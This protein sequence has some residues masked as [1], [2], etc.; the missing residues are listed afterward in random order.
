[1]LEE[2][3]YAHNMLGEMAKHF[4]GSKGESRMRYRDIV[5]NEEHPM[6]LQFWVQ[7]ASS[8]TD[9]TWSWT[10]EYYVKTVETKEDLAKVRSRYNTFINAE[11]GF[12]NK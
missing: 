4:Q 5:R 10:K 2:R 3:D 6:R 12:I 7:F 1:M 8:C 11:L 9:T